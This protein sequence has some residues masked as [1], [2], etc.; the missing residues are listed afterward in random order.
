MKFCNFGT[1]V[2]YGSASNKDVEI[3]FKE[4]NITYSPSSEILTSSYGSDT[5][6]DGHTLR[7]EFHLNS[8]TLILKE[9]LWFNKKVTK[10]TVNFNTKKRLGWLW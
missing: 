5:S 4:G 7:D 3:I 10:N 6:D 2:D 1:S 9:F 8:M